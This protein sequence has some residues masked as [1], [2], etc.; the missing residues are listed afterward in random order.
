MPDQFEGIHEASTLVKPE[1]KGR[2]PGRGAGDFQGIGE[3]QGLEKVSTGP[4]PKGDK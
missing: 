3:Q 2:H 4:K 1:E